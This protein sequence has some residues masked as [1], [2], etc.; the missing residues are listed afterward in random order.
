MGRKVLITGGSGLVGSRL[1]EMLLNDGYQ[2]AHL[3]RSK[4]SQNGVKTYTWDIDNRFVEDGALENA[5]FIIHLA[6]A[7]VADKR[8][9]DDRKQIIMHSRVASTSLLREKLASISHECEA[10]V[11]ASAIG[12]YGWDTGEAWV[13][14]NHQAGEGFLAEVVKAWEHEVNKIREFDL[15]VAMLR[16]GIVLSVDG[17]ALKQMMQPVKFSV[18]APLGSGDQYMSWIHIDDLCRMFIEALKNPGLK[19]IYNAV[20]PNPV[21]N[22]EF[23]ASLAQELDKPQWMPAVPGW[24]LKLVLGEM[25]KMLLGGNRVSCDKIGGQGFRFN[26]ASLEDALKS[27]LN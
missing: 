25:S 21:T 23:T 5:N 6:G 7:G 1:T 15:R 9:T 22:R 11:S 2:V 13:D 19:G 18:G 24:T 17:G 20:A 4:N 10:V 16:I 8:W 27:L 26:F 12:Y 3:S 14:E